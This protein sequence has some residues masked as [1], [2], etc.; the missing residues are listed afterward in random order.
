MTNYT[1]ITWTY[2]KLQWLGVSAKKQN[3]LTTLVFIYLCKDKICSSA[4]IVSIVIYGTYININSCRKTILKDDKKNSLMILEWQG[5]S[6]CN[7]VLIPA[8]QCKL[9][10]SNNNHQQLVP[11]LLHELNKY[12]INIYTTTT[13]HRQTH[14]ITLLSLTIT[15]FVK[16]F[17]QCFVSVPKHFFF[18]NHRS[19]TN[20]TTDRHTAWS[21]H[22]RFHS[23]R[24]VQPLYF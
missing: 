14:K 13:K 23:F 22:C 2:K 6:Q 16:Q 19:S 20:N 10:N 5:C 7:N 1:I 15:T 3:K 12:N 8:I 18:Y 24:K 11:H 21:T 9:S 17:Y 4:I